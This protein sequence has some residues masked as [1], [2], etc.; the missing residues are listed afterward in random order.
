MSADRRLIVALAVSG[1]LNLFLVGGIAGAAWMRHEARREAPVAAA[2]AQR[3]PLWTAGRD[4]P[5][6]H[7][8]ALRR[9]L[10][11]AALENRADAQAARAERRAVVDAMLDG[12]FDRAQADR[13]MAA[14]RTLEGGVRAKVDGRLTAFAE[15]LP[16]EE[17]KVL[18]EG[19]RRVYA[20][21]QKP[22]D[23]GDGERPRRKNREAP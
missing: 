6:E 20:P 14:A 21:R 7:R 1:A 3:P 9:T 18:A 19:L 12:R 15:S 4:L 17:R 23:N 11:E 2:L 16:P 5:P 10:R 8:R 22:R 13:R